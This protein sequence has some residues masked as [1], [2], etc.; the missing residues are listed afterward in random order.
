M[1]KS[2]RVLGLSLVLLIALLAG[3]WGATT[4]AQPHTKLGEFISSKNG[5][6]ALLPTA[7]GGSTTTVPAAA[8]STTT[9]PRTT[10]SVP[11]TGYDVGIQKTGG[12][13]LIIGQ[14]A[15]F[16][17]MPY[18][19]GPSTV[20]SSTGIVVTDVLPANF[21]TPVTVN[22]NPG[23][24]C[25][26]SGVS[27]SCSYIGGSVGAGQPMPSITITAV[28]TKLGE[29]R[30]CAK[31]AIEVAT[32][33]KPSDNEGCVS[34]IV[35]PV[36]PTLLKV[37]KI[38]VPAPAASTWWNS[39][40]QKFNLVIGSNGGIGN[41]TWF[42]KGNGGTTGQ[43]AVTPGIAYNVSETAANSA[44][45]LN[46]YTTT[47]TGVCAPAG[48]V[49]L[50]AG[51]NKTCTITNTRKA[52][53]VII[54]KLVPASDPGR[55]NLQIDGG[56]VAFN[57][58]NNGSTGV[59]LVS[60]T[61]SMHT[62]GEVPFDSGTNLS[63]YVTS[64]SPTNCAGPFT[65]SPGATKTCTITN[66][67]KLIIA[68]E[69][70][71]GLPTVTKTTLEEPV[72]TPTCHV[73][74]IGPGGG[75]V[76]YV[77]ATIINV[78]TGISLGGR[79]LEAA[80]KNWNGT[81]SDPVLPWGCQGAYIGGSGWGIGD[82]ASNTAKILACS[83]T[84]IAARRAANLIFG[85]KSDWFLPSRDELGLMYSNLNSSGVGGFEDDCYW[86]SSELSSVDANYKCFPFGQA[87]TG[88]KNQSRFVRVIRA[89]G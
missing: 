86:T 17:L 45:D 40:P 50:V 81:T 65:I 84:G 25:S 63:N 2:R 1:P 36:P 12:S 48:S 18:N 60:P 38:M 24:N 31:I 49:T 9:V 13:A 51:D 10:P 8:G 57:K 76:F 7:A 79:C 68:T 59:V 30:N 88:F 37:I 6:T 71:V 20:S 35:T 33:T 54:K 28:T 85:G 56:S 70:P 11:A 66:S 83:T 4:A 23:W 87:N 58:G 62:V 82:G 42:N 80:P 44:T 19:T 73:G 26:V 32:D 74:D 5:D 75:I 29:G 72:G 53:L 64:Y 89:Y 34:L 43:V 78:Q 67:R 47:F 46:N 16:I 41:G 3:S 39:I 27:V 22:G 69:L 21:T 14:A 15:T 52:Q 77:S 61:P 55:F